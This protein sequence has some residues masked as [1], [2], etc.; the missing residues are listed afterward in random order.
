[1][2]V[3]IIIFLLLPGLAFSQGPG[4]EV[5]IAKFEHRMTITAVLNIGGQE[6]EDPQDIVAAFVDDEVRGV[7]KPDV[8]HESS[9]RYLVFLQVGSDLAAGETISFS[10]YDSSTGKVT[11]ALTTESFETN[12]IIGSVNTPYAI[13]DVVVPPEE[14]LKMNNYISP[15]NDGFND[16]LVIDQIES[17]V[18]F[19]LSIFNPSGELLFQSD[20]Y[21]NSW[22]GTYN[23]SA[24]PSGIYYYRFEN[25]DIEVIHKGVISLKDK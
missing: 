19:T 12:K 15:N 4:W 7:A 6:S 25:P 24:L 1:M 9:G 20:Q 22:D 23:G 8:F 11:Q 21:D 2:R 3:C 10:F 5:D 13:S 16:Y 17:Y 14:G 18:G